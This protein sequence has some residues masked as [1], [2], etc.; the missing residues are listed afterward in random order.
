MGIWGVL[1]LVGFITDL[2]ASNIDVPDNPENSEERQGIGVISHNIE[3][4]PKEDFTRNNETEGLSVLKENKEILPTSK[5]ETEKPEPYL[6]IPTDK[7]SPP[8][9]GVRFID[10]KMV[11]DKIVPPTPDIPWWERWWNGVTF[12]LFGEDA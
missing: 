3:E 12:W 9:G 5:E 11:N 6:I 8:S 7:L 1:Y 10:P 2:N 4:L